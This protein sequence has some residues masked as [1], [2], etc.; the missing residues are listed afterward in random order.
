MAVQFVQPYRFTE[1]QVARME[2]AGILPRRGAELLDGIVYRAGEPVRFDRGTY[3]RLAEIGVLGEH[4]HV[5][6]IDGEII[7]MTPA[8]SR[9]AACV[10]RITRLLMARTADMIVR[11]EQPLWLPDDYDP[12]PDVAVLRPEPRDYED[13]HPTHHDALVVVE[14]AESSLRYD[15]HVKAERYA[16]AGIPEY[17]LIDLTREHVLIHQRPAGGAYTEIRAYGAGE[18]WRSPVLNGLTVSVDDVIKP[19]S[20]L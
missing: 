8:G 5:E 10:T 1:Q 4:A 14:V 18:S 6:L 11:S 3:Y 7:E 9:H 16:A 15:R 13:A 12:E 2:E 20:A 17:W 19:R